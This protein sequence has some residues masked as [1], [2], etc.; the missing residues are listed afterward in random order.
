MYLTQ[1]ESVLLFS[2]IRI[3]L[4]ST[5]LYLLSRIAS[6][7][8]NLTYLE[9]I[10]GG[11][12]AAVNYLCCTRFSSRRRH[13]YGRVCVALTILIS[14][15]F[16]IL[17]T[18]LSKIYPVTVVH[19][20]SKEILDVSYKFIKPTRLEPNKTSA[21]EVLFNMGVKLDGKIF[22]SY[23]K[24]M[25]RQLPCI[26]IPSPAIRSVACSN[27][28]LLIGMAVP[29]NRSLAIDS[30][31][32]LLD[33]MGGRPFNATYSGRQFNYYNTT[34]R[35]PHYG[36]VQM[37]QAA[38][39]IYNYAF[40]DMVSSGPRT[41]E[42][43]LNQS[44]FERRCVRQSIGYMM[45]RR[46]E[47]SFLTTRRVY[48]QTI[49]HANNITH[50]P[51]TIP[52]DMFYFPAQSC[53][54]FPTPNLRTMCSQI[55]SLGVP[56][57]ERFYSIQQTEQHPDGSVN[58]EVVNA[59]HTAD[60]KNG[61]SQTACILVEAFHLDIHVALF[62]SVLESTIEY[63]D[64]PQSSQNVVLEMGGQESFEA[65]HI[66]PDTVSLNDHSWID[67]GFSD[68]DK[69]NLTEMLFRGSALNGGRFVVLIP[70]MLVDIPVWVAPL[71]FGVSLVTLGL[72]FVFSRSV[73]SIVHEP[74]SEI[75][76]QVKI[77]KVE[78]ARRCPI[79]NPFN[80]HRQ[81]ANLTLE[82]QAPVTDT[83]GK[84]VLPL[85]IKMEIDGDSD[86]AMMLLDN[87]S[88]ATFDSTRGSAYHGM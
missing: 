22:H 77:P 52:N 21:E 5:S 32:K 55:A 39:Q 15:A 60:V 2:A 72:A 62:D 63:A 4:S 76:P 36:M 65:M 49:K 84:T 3:A 51:G 20:D 8:Y 11:F 80:I 6:N 1:E 78:T 19:R 10:N 82:P 44:L 9:R 46:L 12:L 37:F 25:P 14:A 64:I 24:D 54:G 67:W 28:L 41:L 35:S 48:T 45:G 7:T 61:S 31:N 71:C 66:V 57:F 42:A 30:A 53:E 34:A 18:V 81:V 26:V 17:P 56:H 79:P 69:Q 27:E 87:I 40:L 38:A 23:T 70:E 74:M 68:A 85:R 50:R 29:H 59:Y 83:F 75:F 88:C 58:W 33:P 73:P 43:C 86:D 47:R 13:I 16:T